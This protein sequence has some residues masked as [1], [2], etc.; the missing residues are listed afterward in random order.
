MNVEISRNELAGALSALGK[1]VCRTSPVEVYRS[2]RI[3]GK[4]NQISFQTAGVNEAITFMLPA[5]DVEEFAVVVNFDEFRT[6]VRASRNKTLVLEYGE[7]KFGVNHCLMRTVNVEWPEERREKE[8]SE[9]SDLPENFV[10]MLAMAAPLVSRNDY[11]KAL[12]GIHFDRDGM[13]A[14]NSKELLHV[15]LQLAV[16][17]LTIP[18]PHALL[19][20]K[21]NAAGRVVTWC[22]KEQRFFRFEFGNW[23]WTGKA[24]AGMFPNWR[25]IVPQEANLRHVVKL[26]EARASQLAIFLRNVPADPPNNP[27][28]LSMGDD[29]ASLDIAAK[30]MRTVVAAE[31]PLDWGEFSV[32]VNRDILLRLLGEGHSKLSFCDG[33]SPFIATGGIGTFVSMPLAVPHTQPVQPKQEEEMNEMQ[34]P[35]VTAPI[36]PSAAP[37]ITP[38]VPVNPLDDLASAV[39]DFKARLR[40]MCD[41]SVLLARK[42]KEAALAQKQKERDFVQAKRVL[43][44]IRM[45]I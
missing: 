8:G 40:G 6:I 33:R 11:R 28:T 43:E 1:L 7:G 3:E 2:L 37:I 23:R 34:T 24:L 42:V 35:N 44:R 30:E 26:D 38:E 32:T 31:F 4:N 10:G 13:V 14:T 29:H 41:E 20:T 39:D 25:M 36:A 16:T 21:S 22:E 5:E 17:N 45:A 15:P 18:F 9:V 27:V 19:A 12:Q